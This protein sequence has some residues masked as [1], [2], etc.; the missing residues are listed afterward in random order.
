MTDTSPT[1]EAQR[2]AVAAAFDRDLDPLADIAIQLDRMDDDFDPFELFVAF[3]LE[4]RGVTDSTIEDYRRVF[5]QWS[6]FMA[7]QERH[8]ACPNETHVK[9]FI[10][11]ELDEGNQANTI[12]K[13]ISKLQTAYGYWQKDAAFP[14]PQDFDPFQLALD[15][16]KFPETRKKEPPRIP[17]PEL[18]NIVSNAG[19]IRD[20]AIVGLQL[21]L[22]L[23]CG[24]VV[25]IRLPEVSIDDAELDTYYPDM[26]THPRLDD[27]ENAI[28]VPSRYERDGNKSKRSRVMPLDD[29]LRRILLRYLLI[30]PTADKPWL[31]LSKCSQA[32]LEGSDA[33]RAWKAAIGD[34][35]PETDR[36][37]SITSHFGRHRFTTYWRVEQDVNRDLIKYMRGDIIAGGSD[38]EG[39]AIDTYIH[40]YYEDIEPLYRENIYKLGL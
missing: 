4:N 14:H 26:G 13:K 16:V 24:E 21:K 27:R 19:P 35:Y 23:R 38:E 31:F 7:T 28:Y 36:H 12:R 2:E 10:Y 17:I 40:A 22:G 11:N 39:G 33:N 25:N 37:T 32:Q 3:D 29:E 30:R 6:E 9:G 1:V 8:P 15:S 5:R 34:E 18:R 20:R